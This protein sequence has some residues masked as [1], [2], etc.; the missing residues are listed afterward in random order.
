MQLFVHILFDILS[1]SKFQN[2]AARII[3]DMSNNANHSIALR[4]LGWEPL[5]TERKKSKAKMMYRVFKSLTNH[6]LIFF[7]IK[8]KQQTTTFRTSLVALVYQN[9]VLTI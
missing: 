9:H 5:K 1:S 2:R 4:A 7:H 6:S 8:V 3:M